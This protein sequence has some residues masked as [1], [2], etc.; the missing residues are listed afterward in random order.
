MLTDFEDWQPCE[1]AAS[2][3]FSDEI[4]SRDAPNKPRTGITITS[5][6]A[7]KYDVVNGV[8]ASRCCGWV[9]PPTAREFYEALEAAEPD[10]RQC[11]I[12]RC[13]FSE[14]GPDAWIEAKRRGGYSWRTFADAM[15]KAKPRSYNYIRILNSFCARPE[16]VPD[17]LLPTHHRR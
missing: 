9:R 16:L 5:E 11:G 4:D 17:E 12:L 7:D 2:E 10:E 8:F 1:I 13:W 3:A 6:N 15:R 14:G